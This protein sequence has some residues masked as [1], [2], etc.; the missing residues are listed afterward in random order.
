MAPLGGR[1][2]EVG[3]P[4]H[5]VTTWFATVL[6]DGFALTAA[7]APAAFTDV[8]GA[9][10]RVQLAAQPL[11]RP[12][13]ESVDHVLAG[14]SDL[15]LHP[16]VREG[17]EGL[18]GLGVR[19]VTLS[20]GSVASTRGLLDRGGVAHLVDDV[21][22]VDDAGAWKPARNAYAYAARRCGT[23]PEQMML[24]AVHPWDVDGASRAG[25]RTAWIDR[26]GTPYP[27]VFRRPTSTVPSLVGLAAALGA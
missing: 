13:D 14:L 19:C 5:L 23:E 21:L 15:G 7:G 26:T 17:L 11:T 25:L 10:L 8:A 3:A 27:D 18:A 6:R 9:A 2:V 4:E 20:N 24:A 22:S 12:L 16:D 1:L